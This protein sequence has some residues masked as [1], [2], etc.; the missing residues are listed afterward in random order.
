MSNVGKFSECLY[1]RAM[2]L[3]KKLVGAGSAL[4]SSRWLSIGLIVLGLVLVGLSYYQQ[5]SQEL[6]YWWKTNQG[7][8]STVDPTLPDTNH[9]VQTIEPKS[10]DYG[11]VIEK[12][13]VNEVVA[14]N[15]NPYQASIYL[16]VL[17]KTPVAEADFSADPGTNGL[18]YLFGHSTVNIWEIGRYRAPFTLL[19]KLEANDRIIVYYKQQRF[20]YRV[21]KKEIVAP[22]D[23]EVLTAKYNQPT[24]ILQTC[25]PPGQNTKRLLVYAELEDGGQEAE[26]GL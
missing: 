9:K 25:D 20:N 1:T 13:G 16:P 5:I 17:E 26:A 8:Y 11:L 18:T 21:N 2:E 14:N 6:W 24:L 3:K 7:I 4:V 12:I 23:I 22:T 15:I 10:K 19:H